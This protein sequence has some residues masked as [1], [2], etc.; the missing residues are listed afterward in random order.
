[1]YFYTLRLIL[2]VEVHLKLLISQSNSIFFTFQLLLSQTTGI[3]NY[4]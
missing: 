1:M 3:S 4:W 2:K